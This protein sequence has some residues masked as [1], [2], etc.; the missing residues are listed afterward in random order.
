MVKRLGNGEGT[1]RVCCMRSLR[2]VDAYTRCGMGDGMR[3]S[4]RS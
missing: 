3:M 1:G 4:R 2:R